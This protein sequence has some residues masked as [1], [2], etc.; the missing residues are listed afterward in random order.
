MYSKLLAYGDVI[1]IEGHM[2]PH[3]Y[4]RWTNERFSYVRYNPRK[5]VNRF[6]LSLT[7]LDGGV[8]GIPDLDSLYEYNSENGTTYTERDFSVHTA[9][10][11]YQPIQNLISPWKDHI[12]R[13]HVLKL[14]AGGFFPPHRDSREMDITSFRIIMPLENVNP[15]YANFVIDREILRWE[16]GKLY[17]VNTSKMH[18]LF[19]SSFV[20]SYWVVFNVDC[21]EHTVSEVLKR[22]A[23]R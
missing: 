16:T 14:G 12:F 20:D 2:N 21:N 18:Y 11:D 4:V 9:A 15:P 3:D 13:S 7:S 17:F 22:A 1:E 8:S 19:N 5:N 10:F 23:Q 6:G